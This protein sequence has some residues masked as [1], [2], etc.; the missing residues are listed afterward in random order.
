MRSDTSLFDVLNTRIL[1]P[2]V[3]MFRTSP[4]WLNVDRSL[5]SCLIIGDSVLAAATIISR[6]CRKNQQ[7]MSTHPLAA[8][9]STTHRTLSHAS[10]RFFHAELPGMR[11]IPAKAMV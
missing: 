9:L 4:Q 5:I 10:C 11:T 1:A 7:R 6:I 3:V 2:A 8:Q